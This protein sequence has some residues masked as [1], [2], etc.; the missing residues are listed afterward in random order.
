MQV[1]NNKP[2]VVSPTYT[3]SAN[4][5]YEPDK[6]LEQILIDPVLT[7]LVQ[8]TPVTVTDG[9][10]TY[11]KDDLK[12]LAFG[13][14]QDSYDKK[15]EDKMHEL[16]AQVLVHFNKSN[17]SSFHELFLAQASATIKTCPWPTQ[18]I[19]YSITSD[20]IPTCKGFLSQTSS[21]EELLCA[22][23]FTFTPELLGI[24][25]IN[26]IAFEEFK[27]WLKNEI[28]QIQHL[29]KS[30][31]ISMFNDFYKLDL[32]NL[33]EGVILRNNDGD[34]T[35]EFCF[36]RLLVCYLQNYTKIANPD[37][38][39]FLPFHVGELLNPKIITFINVEKHAHSN[40]TQIENEW[41]LINKTLKMPVKPISTKKLSKL[42]ATQRAI[43][44]TK[45]KANQLNRHKQQGQ[46][47][48]S[49]VIKFRKQAYRPV[50]MTTIV[51]K[52]LKKMHS[53]N[54]SQNAYK[55]VKMSYA[56]PNRRDPDNFNLKGKIVST[57]YYPD[58]HLYVDT[59]GSIN[60]E[61]YEAC[62]KACINLAKK[63]NINLYFN[64]F[65][66]T[67]STSTLLKTKD[68][69]L[70]QIY[71]EFEKIP[72]VTGGTDFSLV[73]EYINQSKKRQKELSLLITDFGYTAPNS[74]SIVHPKQLYYIPVANFNWDAITR[75]A[76]YFAESMFKIDPSI[77][78]KM[79][80]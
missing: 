44:A 41:T 33:T 56:R 70:T 19:A 11:T 49:A 8:N 67:L 54:K 31:T 53:I 6:A 35:K 10:N 3:L 57:K 14:M 17:P 43:S 74:N 76:E 62:I 39:G 42:S 52:L 34:A 65:S 68:K 38:F 21:V 60:T 40:K 58:I 48:K 45:M 26:D 30:N 15:S 55:S 29:L 24:Y 22:F 61:N 4:G 77:R 78:R 51:K 69:S 80:L 75:W 32:K 47:Q 50:D 79:M 27:T 37:H 7:P 5:D 36:A 16:L 46:V 25:F 64:S 20:I 59:S 72:K 2:F 63:L 1:S 71:K 23:G 12:E 18:K 66:D 13:C 73:W 28:N 9:S